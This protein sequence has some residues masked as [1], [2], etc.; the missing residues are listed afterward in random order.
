MFEELAVN[1]FFSGAENLQGIAFG[2]SFVGSIAAFIVYAKSRTHLARAPYF[3]LTM[4]LLVFASAMS[5]MWLYGF[6][7]TAAGTLWTLYA[8]GFLFALISGYFYGMMAIAR[9]RD[10][11][12]TGRYAILSY[13]PLLNLVLLLKPSKQENS[14]AQIPVPRVFR[15]ALGV[16]MGFLFV[17]LSGVFTAIDTGVTEAMKE[18]ADFETILRPIIQSKGIEKALTLIAA[19]VR[20][21]LPITVDEITQFVSISAEQNRIQRTFV[22]SNDK[23]VFSDRFR[24]SIPNTVCGD[25]SLSILIRAGAELE[26]IYQAADGTELGRQIVAEEQCIPRWYTADRDAFLESYGIEKTLSIMA[27]VFQS[28]LPI[29]TD[30]GTRMVSLETKGHRLLRTITVAGDTAVL[31]PNFNVIVE[32]K[33]CAHKPLVPLLRAGAE[34]VD[35]YTREDGTP[36]GEFTVTKEHCGQ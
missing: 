14:S 30:D 32:Q 36:L 6:E 12:G 31:K 15:G 4:L 34:I 35:T 2:L 28:F 3:S 20:P 5:F 1:H 11:F 8:A 10:A 27:E 23:F 33:I 26:E 16:T 22:I 21:A 19:S 29:E 17:V 9:S 25:E 7:A 18:E 13:I 24:S